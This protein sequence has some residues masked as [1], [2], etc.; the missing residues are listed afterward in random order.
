MTQGK[1]KQPLRAPR[2][3][4]WYISRAQAIAGGDL[5]DVTQ[6]ARDAGISWPVAVTSM[7]WSE[8]VKV[9]GQ[10]D[11]NETAH[12]CHLLNSLS[13]ALPPPHAGWEQV[14]F[15][16]DTPTPT[17]NAFRQL[18]RPVLHLYAIRGTS[19][20]GEPVITVKL[21]SEAYYWE[22]ALPVAKRIYEALAAEKRPDDQGI[23]AC[24]LETPKHHAALRYAV[25]V[26]GVTVE[27]LAAALWCGHRLQTLIGPTNPHRVVFRDMAENDSSC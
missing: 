25:R 16:V 2:G 18:L 12:L 19:D 5:K 3:W 23:V 11:G 22:E 24:L 21:P 26:D 15:T 8:A 14:E 7:V 1:E 20:D 27:H 13:L 10:T 9:L 4:A 17:P 6:Y